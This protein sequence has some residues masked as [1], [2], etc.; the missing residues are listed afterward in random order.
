MY[1]SDNR[2]TGRSRTA[3][4]SRSRDVSG[5]PYRYL[6]GAGVRAR[7]ASARSELR[8]LQQQESRVGKVKCRARRRLP[9]RVGPL[10]D[11]PVTTR[12]RGSGTWEAEGANL[13]CRSSAMSVGSRRQDEG[14]L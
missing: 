3:G 7:T 10:A 1:H 9:G 11:R 8:R 4:P 6:L 13:T 5:G 2:E 12:R 14:P